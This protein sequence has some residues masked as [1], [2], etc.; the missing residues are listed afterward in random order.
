MLKTTAS[1]VLAS[2]TRSSERHDLRHGG[3]PLAFDRSERLKRS[4]VWT[5][6]LFRSLRP[7]QWKGA[8][9]RARA[10]WMEMQPF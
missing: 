5:S 1:F 3:Y 10:G 4:L 6:S 8:S 2:L 9:R 7:R